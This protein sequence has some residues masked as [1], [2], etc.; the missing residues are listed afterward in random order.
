MKVLLLVNKHVHKLLRS[1][2]SNNDRKNPFGDGEAAR[3]IIDVI[4][5]GC[6][7]EFQEAK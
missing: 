5:K 2:K 1:K 3:R 6:C 4:V 7:K